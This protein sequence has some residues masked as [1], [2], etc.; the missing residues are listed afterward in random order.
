MPTQNIKN[1]FRRRGNA[2]CVSPGGFSAF[3]SLF[4]CPPGASVCR[5]I[6]IFAERNADVP[7][8]KTVLMEKNETIEMMKARRS[9]R[10]FKSDPV[11]RELPQNSIHIFFYIL[12][13]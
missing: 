9:V 4:R 11:P 7:S 12:Y 10:K 1:A 5:K 6:R 2:F 8:E 13:V 3:L